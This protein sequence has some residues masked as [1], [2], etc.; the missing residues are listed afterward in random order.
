[1]LKMLKIVI[2]SGIIFKSNVSRSKS[3]KVT[4]EKI[5]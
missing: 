2:L 3:I 4:E 1:M 5:F